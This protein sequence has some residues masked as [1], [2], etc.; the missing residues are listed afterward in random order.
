[1]ILSFM[2]SITTIK[3]SLSLTKYHA[4][5]W[6]W[7]EFSIIPVGTDFVGCQ[8][9]VKGGW[10]RTKHPALLLEMR[11]FYQEL[12]DFSYNAGTLKFPQQKISATLHSTRISFYQQ[13]LN[14]NITILPTVTALKKQLHSHFLFKLT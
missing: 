1:M 7:S 11:S 8:R 9:R 6:I 3:T 12:L 4:S 10:V 2:V 5:L 13:F 14:W